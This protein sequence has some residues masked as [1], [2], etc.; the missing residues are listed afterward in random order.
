MIISKSTDRPPLLHYRA[1]PTGPRR[2]VEMIWDA[3]EQAWVSPR[4]VA[5]VVKVEMFGTADGPIGIGVGRQLDM[6]KLTEKFKALY[7]PKI[8][9]D[10]K[11]NETCTS[12]QG[13]E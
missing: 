7:E 8:R 11:T 9:G 6:G 2:K 4:P 1:T 12:F 3:A 10:E 13:E 5:V